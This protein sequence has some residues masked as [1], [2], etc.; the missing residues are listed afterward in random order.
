MRGVKKLEKLGNSVPT[1]NVILIDWLTVTFHDIEVQDVQRMLGLADPDIDWDYKLAFRHGYPRQT[2]FS[3]I[4]IRYGADKVENYA[5]DDKKSAADKVRFDMGVCLDMSGNGCR[6]YETYGHGDWLMLLQTICNLDTRFNI[7]RLDLAYDDHIGILDLNRI[8]LD[9]ESRYYT[10]SPKKAQVIWSDDQEDDI[11][12]LTVYI[13]SQKSPVFIR[14]YDKAAERG[15]KDRHWIRVEL[16]L[17][18]D[19]ATAAIAEILHKEDIGKVFSG[20]LRNYCCF[21]EPT[22]DTNKSRWPI[23]EY[24]ENLINGVDRIRLWISPGEPYNFRKT[25]EHMINQYG[26]A[27]QAF[28]MIHGNI[29]DLLRMSRQVHPDLKKKYK[30]AI[31]EARMEQKRNA[32][33]LKKLR[34]DLGIVNS[35]DWSYVDHQIDM[36]EIFGEDLLPSGS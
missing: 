33:M 35:D 13:G 1:E 9:V 18:H 30:V 7:T 12:G 21:R 20:V 26:Q 25:E 28:E 24:W 27:L 36:A 23:A 34:K 22:D 5:D 32:A 11:Q 19:R 8:R 17:R 15:F 3:N 2:T 31:N 6:A 14:I 10:G 29:H 4:V 16:Q